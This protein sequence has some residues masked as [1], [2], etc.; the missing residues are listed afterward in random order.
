MCYL[1]KSEP[2]IHRY[3][4]EQK[5]VYLFLTAEPFLDKLEAR[6]DDLRDPGRELDALSLKSLALSA[7][8]NS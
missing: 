7:F 2:L 4:I 6:L 8:F 1:K 3:T 5:G